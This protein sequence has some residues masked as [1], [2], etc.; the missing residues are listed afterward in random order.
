MFKRA[1]FTLALVVLLGLSSAA[2]SVALR[3]LA[4]CKPGSD[5]PIVTREGLFRVHLACDH[6]LLEIPDRMY[7]RDMLLNTEFAALS[8]SSIFIAPGTV[9]DNRVVRWVRRGNKVQL[10]G[11][12]YEIASARAPGIERSVEAISGCSTGW[13]ATSASYSATAG[14]DRARSQALGHER[15]EPDSGSRRA[16]HAQR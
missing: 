10:V 14:S 16:P 13:F 11:I 3:E 8:G 9:V 12:N 5:D 2:E 6:L 7:N 1:F 15:S 4:G